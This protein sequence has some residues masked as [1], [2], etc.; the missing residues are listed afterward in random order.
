M[1]S[2]GIKSSED[3]V[4]VAGRMTS[5][6][7]RGHDEFIGCCPF[8][9]EKT[10]S[11]K[12]NQS[13]G[14]FHCFGCGKDG[15]VVDLLAH[16]QGVSVHELLT[17]EDSDSTTSCVYDINKCAAIYYGDSLI[18]NDKMVDLLV[19]RGMCYDAI[20][21]YGIGIS[22]HEWDSISRLL[23]DKFN[24]EDVLESGLCQ[25]KK[26]GDG[27]Y[28]SFRGR[29]MFPITRA[30]GR[31]RG[32][33]GRAIGNETLPKYIN[34][35][36][37]RAY[38]KTKHLFGVKQSIRE[39]RKKR[40]YVIVEGAVDCIAA[41]TSGILNVVATLGTALTDDHVSFIKNIADTVYLAF[42]GDNAG[43]MA[44]ESAIYKLLSKNID[45]RCV[46][47]ED[48]MDVADC[49]VAGIDMVDRVNRSIPWYDFIVKGIGRIDTPLGVANAAGK[50]KGYVECIENNILREETARVLSSSTGIRIEYLI[51]QL[52][53]TGTVEIVS[54]EKTST[55][56]YNDSLEL[57]EWLIDPGGLIS[58]G[59]KSLSIPGL[60]EPWQ[61]KLPVVLS[62]IGRAIT[63]KIR[64]PQA[65]PNFYHVIIAPSGSGKSSACVEMQRAIIR[66][67]LGDILG[68]SRFSS[69]QA[70]FSTLQND[71]ANT[72][73]FL[74]E[75]TPLLSQGG[76]NGSGNSAQQTKALLELYSLSGMTSG[77]YKLNY[78]NKDR[79]VKIDGLMAFSFC[80]CATPRCFNSLSM[81]SLED[82]F[83]SRANIWYREGMVKPRGEKLEANP[84]IDD[85][86][87]KIYFV[88][89]SGDSSSEEG[90]VNIDTSGVKNN[91]RH[92]DE[93]CSDKINEDPMNN[94][95]NSYITKVYLDSLRYAMVHMASSREL[96]C[97]ADPMEEVDIRYGHGIAKALAE[98]K[99]NI[100]LSKVHS[101]D[102]EADWREFISGMKAAAPRAKN[103]MVSRKAISDRRK[104]ANNW[105]PRRWDEII[106]FLHSTGRISINNEGRCQTY[107]LID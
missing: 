48:G 87:N 94:A 77:E 86:C 58:S 1:K 71:G 32:F 54:S 73:C 82:G 65:I 21:E 78:A 95:R 90:G 83:F 38:N 74:D 81:E 97:I 16:E 57:E 102:F 66:A 100:L 34:T 96:W 64:H 3:V 70:I 60:P 72:L 85:F 29:I 23:L 18:T 37:C 4:N 92:I 24:T 105:T 80:G 103:G 19:S 13:T 61:Y 76:K 79:N 2:D 39:A 104:K 12:V 91:L 43:R 15:T 42:D 63:G 84:L 55:E 26:K 14:R 93:W 20:L 5:L 99:I 46:E 17:G 53:T 106:E 27:L 31:I 47:I 41:W 35:K 69:E 22:G 9:N 98:W 107:T 10:P 49:C 88:L 89:K 30:D 8:H 56:E 11:F 68:P 75:I 44:T 28:D 25:K 45:V 40:S 7:R 52:S 50:I 101:G 59:M 62:V 33:S 51:E 6:S 67:G 36:T